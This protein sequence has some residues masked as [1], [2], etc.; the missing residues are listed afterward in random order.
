MADVTYNTSSFPSLIRTVDSVLRLV[1]GCEVVLAY[2]ERHETERRILGM[3]ESIGLRMRK[4]DHIY[5]FGAA[6][7]EVWLGGVDRDM[8]EGIESIQG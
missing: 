4:I 5:G 2:K 7:V 1:P 8:P 6:E 3:F